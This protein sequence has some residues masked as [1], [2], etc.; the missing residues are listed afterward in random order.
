MLYEP[1]GARLLV[2]HVAQALEPT[3]RVGSALGV[4]LRD[5][6][7]TCP[8]AEAVW[9]LVVFRAAEPVLLLQLACPPGLLPRERLVLA[10]GRGNAETDASA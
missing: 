7:A 6:E 3:A 4:A 1:S 8:W 9:V 2:A 10:S 5:A